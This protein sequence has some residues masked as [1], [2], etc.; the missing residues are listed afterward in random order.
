MVNVSASLGERSEF[1][2]DTLIGVE[3]SG[4]ITATEEL[5][6]LSERV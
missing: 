5:A 2:V 3:D 6:D 1:F 4:M